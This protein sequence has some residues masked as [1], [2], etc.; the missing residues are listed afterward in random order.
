MY[1]SL[2]RFMQRGP[3]SPAVHGTLDYLLAATLIAAP[4]VLHFHDETAKAFVLAVGGA[5]SLLAVGTAWS[6]GIV[7]VVPPVVHG[8]ADVGATVALIVAPFVLGYSSHTLAMVF[9]VAAGAGGLGAVLMTRFVSDLAP[10][11]PV[12]GLAHPA[13]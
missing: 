3:V 13:R 2:V 1:S 4:L 9:C 11:A 8:L 7:R 12:F 5:A 6:R 10:M